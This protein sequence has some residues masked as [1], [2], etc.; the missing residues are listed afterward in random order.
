MRLLTKK[1]FYK[2]KKKKVLLVSEASY[3][4]SGYS[5]YGYQIMKR[6]YDTKDFDLAEISCHG[7][8]SR[9]NE[10]PWKSYVVPEKSNIFGEDILND[11]LID[12][13]PDI[14]WSFRDPWIDEFI[15]DCVLRNHFKWVYMPTVDALPLDIDWIDTIN[16]AD[17]I[18][19]YTDWAA[20]ELLKMCP[21]M[22][23]VG[24]AS[25]GFDS[26][27]NPTEDKLKFKKDN[28]IN[29][30]ALII[31]SVMR[32]Q[33][34]KL[35]PDLF[36]AFC[37]YLEN[38]PKELSEKTFLYL[39]T[40]YP[41]VGWNI[42]RLIAERPKLSNKLLFSYN[43]NTCFKLSISNFNGAITK[44]NYCNNISCTFPRVTKGSKRDDMVM[45]YNLM[46]LYVQ[47]SCAEGFGMPLVEAASCGVPICAVNYSAM[48]D[49]V[50]KLEGYPIEVERFTYEVETNRKFALPNNKNFVDICIDF[51]KKPYPLRKVISKK[52]RDLVHKFF[53]YDDTFKKIKNVFDKISQSDSWDSSVKQA[54]IPNNLDLNVSNDEFINKIFEKMPINLGNI[55][56]KCLFKLNYNLYTKEK[57]LNELKSIF[58]TYNYYDSLRIKK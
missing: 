18:F 22:N 35:I 46:D 8:K 54:D 38:A 48:T 42:P 37:D 30:E 26:N 23:V 25:P 19:T 41:D 51:L 14:V 44:C 5:N 2:M 55:K 58:T 36:D 16:R 32:N 33:K 40:T 13:K 1:K 52:T 7:N 10:I 57:M 12:F 45:V 17:Y 3:L 20:N 24:S 6:L 28:G 49:I 11:V 50:A 15:G 43:C 29:E 27:F 4:N 9:S 34:R 56:Q 31:G 21:E 39:H 53:N 47:Y